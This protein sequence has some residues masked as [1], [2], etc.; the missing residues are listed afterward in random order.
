[1]VWPQL[2]TDHPGFRAH[3]FFDRTYWD[4]FC[5]AG[6]SVLEQHPYAA[7]SAA[8]GLGPEDWHWGMET[9]H[10]GVPHLVASDTALFY[11]AKASGSVQGAHDESRSLLPPSALLTDDGLAG[12][13][14]LVEDRRGTTWRGLQRRILRDHG[15]ETERA[16]VPDPAPGGWRGRRDTWPAH[17]RF[18]RPEVARRSDRQV[19]QLAERTDFVGRPRRAR[20]SEEELAAIRDPGFN[21]LHYRALNAEALHLADGEAIEHFLDVGRAAHLR[22]AL[23][24]EELHDL[25]VLDLPDYR[26]LHLDL[27]ALDADSLLHHYLVHGRAEGRAGS[28]TAEQRQAAEPIALGAALRTELE[29]MHDLDPA[30]PAPT[31]PSSLPSARS[32]HRPTAR[33]PRAA[34][35]GGRSSVPSGRRDPPRSPSAP[36]QAATRSGP[37]TAR[38]STCR[39]WRGG[40]DW[41][42]TSGGG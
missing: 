14:D 36:A 29:A 26:D 34:G 1:M 16:V 5:L 3:N 25:G 10:A 21:V 15:G 39:A 19:R 7:T 40:P 33:S 8:D 27:G 2:P 31:P 35:R 11:R 28:M 9:V 18:L 13:S 6:R 24:E 17:V 12:T 4:T 38:R 22:T 30:V 20:L 32:A 37:T 23:S 42:T 41:A